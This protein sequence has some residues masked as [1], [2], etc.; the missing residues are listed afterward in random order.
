MASYFTEND[1]HDVT[2]WRNLFWL[3]AGLYFVATLIFPILVR[4]RP[5]EFEPNASPKKEHILRGVKNY[6]TTENCDI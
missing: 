5:A 1:P 2:G 4:I 3:S 6:G